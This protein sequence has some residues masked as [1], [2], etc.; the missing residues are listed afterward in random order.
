MQRDLGAE[1]K[2]RGGGGL[3]SEAMEDFLGIPKDCD[4]PC[5]VCTVEGDSNSDKYSKLN[6]VQKRCCNRKLP[7]IHSASAE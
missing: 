4:Y 5:Q 2:T 1:E 7:M 3:D 6:T